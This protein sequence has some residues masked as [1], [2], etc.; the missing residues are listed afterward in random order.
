MKL[1]KRFSLF[2]KSL[3]LTLA[4]SCMLTF[5]AC[6]NMATLPGTS[7]SILGVKTLD[8]PAELKASNGGKRKIS[9]KWNVVSVAKYYR[10]YCSDS[11]NGTFTQ[12]GE[13]IGA[14]YDDVVASGRTYY[15][16]VSAVN[17]KGAESNQSE[18]VKG[19]SL[20]TPIISNITEEDTCATVEWYTENASSY[21]DIS[22]FEVH[23]TDGTQDYSMVVSGDQ[24]SYTFY[25]LSANTSYQFYVE[26]YTTKDPN[27]VEKS[28]TVTAITFAQYTPV[29]P[30]FSASQGDSTTG[31]KLNITLPSRVQVALES[32]GGT[33]EI[34]DS[35]LY[36][37]VYRK[38]AS[39]NSY[40]STPLIKKLYFDGTTSGTHAYDAYTAGNI[41][42]YVDTSV[43]RGVKYE[44]QIKSYIDLEFPD[45]VSKNYNKVLGSKTGKSA[46]G[47]AAA[48]P[49]FEIVN[50]KRVKSDND[51][52]NI[53]SDDFIS[54]ISVQ[55]DASWDDMGKASVYRYAV[56]EK[57]TKEND[58]S[59]TSET[60]ISD[61]SGN[62]FLSNLDVINNIT[63]TF[64]LTQNASDKLGS[65]DYVLYII[66][67]ADPDGN[68]YTA[69]TDDTTKI[70]TYASATSSVTV[71]NRVDMPSTTFTSYKGGWTNKTQLKWGLEEDVQYSLKRG[72][73]HEDKANWITIPWS[74]ISQTISDDGLFEDTSVEGGHIYTYELYANGSHNTGISVDVKTLGTPAPV[75]NSYDYDKIKVTWNDNAVQCAAYY[76]VTLG[77]AQ[78]V[79]NG[80]SAK[81]IVTA[82]NKVEME[83]S[84][85]D[86][87]T[88]ASIEAGEISLTI[89]NPTNY[90]DA[91]ISGL[92]SNLKIKAYSDLES[93]DEERTAT[94][95]ENVCT[96]GP[97]GIT[98]TA[99]VAESDTKIVVTWNKVDGAGAYL[100]RRDRMD[101]SNKTI[102]LS[103]SYIVP[104]NGGDIQAGYVTVATN[105]E[106]KLVLT[107]TSKANDE[108]GAWERNQERLAWGYPYRYTIF[109]LLKNDDSTDVSDTH[110]VI[111][112]KVDSTETSTEV[113]Y[114]N[115][116]Q[117]SAIGSTN[118]YGVN[119]LATKSQDPHRVKITWTAP[120]STEGNNPHLW[121]SAD[122]VTWTKQNATASDNCFIVTPTGDDRTS[123]FY[124]AVSYSSDSPNTAPHT[125]YTTEI[126]ADKDVAYSPL[127]AK[128]LGYPFALVASA[129]NVPTSDGHAGFS[130][131]FSYELWDYTKRRVGPANSAEYTVSVKNNNFGDGYNLVAT[132][133]KLKVI[134]NA[135]I[136]GYEI[137]APVKTGSGKASQT[138]T[139]TPS[140]VATNDSAYNTGLLSVLR[141]YKHYYKL[142]VSR[143]LTETEVAFVSSDAE[144]RTIEAS[145]C[146]ADGTTDIE[147]LYT[148]RNITNAELAKAAMLAM[149]YGFYKA[150]GGNAD[151][152][153]IGSCYVKPEGSDTAGGTFSNSDGALGDIYMSG[154][155]HHTFKISKDGEKGYAPAMLTPGGAYANAVAISTTSQ[156]LKF[157]RQGLNE[158]FYCLQDSPTLNVSAA[159]T[160]VGNIYNATITVTNTTETVYK[161]PLIG[162]VL[163]YSYSSGNDYLVIDVQRT[164]NSSSWSYT[165]DTEAERREYFPIQHGSNKNW[166]F[167][168][169]S[170]GWWGK[171]Q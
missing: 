14:S 82:T 93:T 95:N 112:K 102:V 164:Y 64:D 126:S 37:E 99:T 2:K 56:K 83:G 160:Q 168:N 121:R 150:A 44:Y 105:T 34:I 88:T 36:F 53:A 39:E 84:N 7:S 51:T 61:A 125:A 91:T 32:T 115:E 162:T 98:T 23:C 19:T 90:D 42:S 89:T 137:E 120:Y 21:E 49:S 153:N 148:F 31:V 46:P 38:R 134:K 80:A 131:I 50:Y 43:T 170:Y 75:F 41:M 70:L 149:T 156:S 165:A 132:I 76:E 27:D 13:S 124:Y 119:V 135:D 110:T 94:G 146:D 109:P 133:D 144:N 147:P 159:N 104:E 127:E 15:Y 78:T 81:F 24:E 85:F 107:D 100:V 22:C 114:K 58:T 154:K 62:T 60:W 139:L 16:R 157:W 171:K 6:K 130:E 103:D 45:L 48:I 152:S 29:A 12:V 122:G 67:E 18:I 1:S 47:W 17:G 5:A 136:S 158:G 167:K 40:P 106:G 169:S 52:P 74:T 111:S 9:L 166:D 3:G 54:S 101:S 140:K 71:S 87:G 35:P 63:K 59:V 142:G 118:G 25:N 128:N 129:A 10:I 26:L 20:A 69:P 138:I 72:K 145:W 57:F 28:A 113:A 123:A 77:D 151:Y 117:L 65:Y 79:G 8:A 97:A 68:A 108:S 116:T 73:D 92:A 96:L 161:V 33:V 155:Y 66:P 30:E 55:F 141:D 86:S 11:P 143:D 163:G 4:A